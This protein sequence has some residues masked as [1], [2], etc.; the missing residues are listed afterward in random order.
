MRR[1]FIVIVLATMLTGCALFKPDDSAYKVENIPSRFSLY[2]E[3]AVLSGKW[4]EDLNSAELNRLVEE[5]VTGNFSISEAWARLE[6]ARAAAIKTQASLFPELSFAAGESYVEQK[7]KG[8]AKTNT[9]AW[10]L[11][12]SAS[13]EVDL[14]GRVRA[15][16]KSDD[17]LAR[18]TE[19]DFKTALTTVAGQIAENWISLIANKKQQQLLTRQLALQNELLRLIQFRFPLGKATALDIYQQ[20]Q[21]IEKIKAAL[22]PLVG[23]EGE[24]KRQLALFLGKATI[25]EGRLAQDIFPEAGDIPAIGL[26]AD[27]LAARPDVRAAGLRLQSAEWTIAEAKAD[28]LPA[29]KLTASHTYS[30]DAFRTVF[31]NWLLNLAGNLAGP[32]IDGRQ[33]RMEV[34]RSKAIADERLAA[35]G[36]TV[37]TAIK[38]VEDA[39]A[40]EQQYDKTIDTLA[41]Q[42]ALSKRTMREAKRRYLNGNSDFLNVLREELNSLQIQQ[43]NIAAQE[44]K[45][46][47]RIDLYRTLGGSWMN[48]YINQRTLEKLSFRTLFG[49]ER[50]PDQK[51]QP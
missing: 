4:W 36:K 51:V 27:L 35:Y 44:K 39:L 1:L 15:E 5:A 30:S 47:A 20:Q 28:R 9:D 11:G 25:E 26:P 3:K 18:A 31:D 13:Y 10:S 48:T 43:D 7:N 37:F 29:L 12:L 50:H 32:I 21:S 40:E 41:R 14:W 46:L 49:E 19:E 24:I 33:R 17:L 45:L 8:A 42:L 34:V 22:I 6:Q 38:E 2:S 16:K 23:R